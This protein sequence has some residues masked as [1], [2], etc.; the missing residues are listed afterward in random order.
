MAVEYL[1]G[2]CSCGPSTL[3]WHSAT[4]LYPT[5]RFHHPPPLLAQPNFSL[6]DNTLAAKSQQQLPDR[7]PEWL[8]WEGNSESIWP[9]PAQSRATK[10]RLHRPVSRRLLKDVNFHFPV[11]WEAFGTVKLVPAYSSV[12][13]AHGWCFLELSPG[14]AGEAFKA[15]AL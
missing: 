5:A 14:K 4:L 13:L 9:K 6:T 12:L 2:C 15:K 10:S 7:I 8:R 3:W 1:A 11:C